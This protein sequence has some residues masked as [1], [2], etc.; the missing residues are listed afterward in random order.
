MPGEASNTHTGERRRGTM[1]A[2]A[3]ALAAIVGAVLLSPSSAPATGLPQA[4]DRSRPAIEY[5]PGEEPQTPSGRALLIPCRFGTGADAGEPSFGFGQAGQIF[6]ETWDLDAPATL[7]GVVRSNDQ[8]HTWSVASPPGIVTSLDPILLIDPR[9]KR[10]FDANYAGN[11][12]A[13]CES[14]SY[15]DDSGANWTTHDLCGSG[16]DGGSLGVGPPVPHSK[17]SGYPNVVYYCASASLG[18]APPPSSP[19]CAKSLDGGATF[20]PITPP[21]PIEGPAD[22]FANWSGPP[23]VGRDGTVYVPKRSGGEPFVAISH[24]E[25]NSWV[26]VQVATNGDSSEDNR[27]A[28]DRSGNLYYAWE[29]AEHLPYFSVSRDEGKNWSTSVQ[30]APAGVRETALAR[31][32]VDPKRGRLAVVYLGSTNAP[33]VPPYYPFC[34]E[35]LEPCSDGSYANATWTGYLTTVEN[36]LLH[37]PPLRTATTNSPAKPL[38][39][40]G[41]SPDGGCKADVDFLDVHFDSRGHPWGAFVDD[42]ALTAEPGAPAK[43]FNPQ[44]GPCEDGTGEGFLLELR[45]S[46]ARSR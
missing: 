9:T 31:V 39:V 33:G 45:R 36:P 13:N 34:Q 15:S 32:A 17:T 37:S 18:S 8:G 7:S 14:I 6:Y 1:R 28:I 41:C 38:F 20:T 42:C 2:A 19:D 46:T 25:G 23:V 40:G 22:E 21:F 26:D 11:G 35:Y 24:D 27:M 30:L 3:V 43:V 16:F 44:F 12:N 4:C 29:G 10:V 5:R